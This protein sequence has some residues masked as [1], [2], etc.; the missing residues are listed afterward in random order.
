M[1][2]PNPARRLDGAGTGRC[3]ESRVMTC[4]RRQ[5]I[6]EQTV[7]AGPPRSIDANYDDPLPCAFQRAAAD[8]G[9]E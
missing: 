4:G 8:G 3:Q 6:A 9:N 5:D 7:F 1:R 2:A